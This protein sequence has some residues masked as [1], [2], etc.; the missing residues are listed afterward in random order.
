MIP[1]ASLAPDDLPKTPVAAGDLFSFAASFFGYVVWGGFEPCALVANEVRDVWERTDRWPMSLT[2]LRTA[3]FFESR[4]E[5]FVD[6]GGFAE[7]PAGYEEHHEYMR[8]LLEGIR[9]AL[10]DHQRDD[11]AETVAEW[12][13]SRDPSWLETTELESPDDGW[14]RYVPEPIDDDKI[15]AACALAARMIAVDLAHG[16]KVDEDRLRERLCLAIRHLAP[17]EVAKEGGIPISGFRGA[18]PVDIV[19]RD[20]AGSE[21]VGL[22]EVKWS[23]ATRRDKIYEAAWDAIKLVL[24]EAPRAERWLITGA[25]DLSWERTETLDLF[26][27]GFVDTVELWSRELYKRGPNGGTTVGGDCEAGGY[28]NM[29]TY[30]PE[31]IRIKHVATSAVPAASRSVRAARVVAGEGRTVP[32]A[33]APEFPQRI[34]DPWLAEHV[35]VMAGDQYERLLDWLHLKRWTESELD[36]RVR[37]LRS[38]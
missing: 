10:V 25:P 8:V 18:G 14:L 23:V 22:I 26:E 33:S 3:L 5:R 4:R 24:A 2:V 20:R 38:P 28:G 13:E 30:A 15:A 19:L 27:D 7:D 35:P 1:N 21:P 9:Q 6:F 16:V 17:V 34:T 32:F 31:R 29:F 11:E 12:L 37:S 36:A